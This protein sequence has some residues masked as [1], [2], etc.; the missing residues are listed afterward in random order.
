MT[1]KQLKTVKSQLQQ[2]NVELKDFKEELLAARTKELEQTIY[3][4]ASKPHLSLYG[5]SM[6]V[7][8]SPTLWQSSSPATWRVEQ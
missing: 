4:L 7:G 5:A 6:L 2:L 3:M 8:K 1:V